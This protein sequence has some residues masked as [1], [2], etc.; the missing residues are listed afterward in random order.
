[1]DQSEI[2]EQTAEFASL[3][4]RAQGLAQRSSASALAKA[5]GRDFTVL[6]SGTVA[7]A[8]AR[9]GMKLAQNPFALAQFQV[10]LWADS[11]K[12]WAG[13]WVGEGHD[14]K[15]RRFR[16]GRWNSNPVSRGLRD[17]HLAIEG[18]ADRLIETLPDGDKDSL[19]VRFYTRQL[20]SALSPSNYLALNPV[21]RESGSWKPMAAACWTGSA[22]CWM[23]LS[24]ARD[25]WTST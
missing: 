9:A 18:A 7:Q 17:V 22:T 3:M 15:D 16:D 20:L 1:M 25:G 5:T 6:D 4:Q 2:A 11:A 14:S 19:R 23:I 8:Y 21:P 10:D 24:A 12:A 13:A